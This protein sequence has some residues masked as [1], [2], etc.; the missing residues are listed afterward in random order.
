MSKDR[1]IKIMIPV[2][3]SEIKRKIIGVF[4]NNNLETKPRGSKMA[5]ID[6]T[7]YEVRPERL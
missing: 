1:F 2:F 7:M 5:R 4:S 3:G 6:S